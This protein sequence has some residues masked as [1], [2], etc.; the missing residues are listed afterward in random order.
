MMIFHVGASYKTASLD[1]LER[2]KQSEQEQVKLLLRVAQGLVEAVLLS[3]CNRVEVYGVASDVA[4]AIAVTREELIALGGPEVA[5]KLV[6]QQGEE[7]LSHLFN[8]ASGLASPVPGDPQVLGQVKESFK[9][10]R[11]AGSVRGNLT[12]VCEASLNCAKKVRSQTGI[13]QGNV[14]TASV[15]VALVLN[16]LKTLSDKTVLVVGAGEIGALVAKHVRYNGVGRLLIANRTRAKAEALAS[17]VGGTAHGLDELPELLKEVDV[18]VCATNAH[19]PLVTRALVEPVGE[20]R[21]FRHLWLIDLA[22]PRNIDPKVSELCW[23]E[24][25]DMDDINDLGKRNRAARDDEATKAESIVSEAVKAFMHEQVWRDRN[26]VLMSLRPRTE[27]IAMQQVQE[28]LRGAGAGL[29]AQQRQV[30]IRMGHSIVNKL[31]HPVVT[32]LQEERGPG[33]LAV[34]AAK[35]FGLTDEPASSSQQPLGEVL[36]EKR[37]SAKGKEIAKEAARK[38]VRLLKPSTGQPVGALADELSESI[39]RMGEAIIEKLLHEPIL[40]LRAEAAANEA[41]G[42]THATVRLFKLE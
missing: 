30:L 26:S 1:A 14:S 21:G 27:Q 32:C 36:I 17:E 3:T 34:A 38:T 11:L 20:A 15:A 18:A 24:S 19:E 7:A 40:R 28:W 5:D 29:T 39:E 4:K 33:C 31:L 42:L 37:L 22:N 8:V 2:L 10:G 23:V 25:R 12:R 35:L 16:F 9:L 6:E 13:G 41:N